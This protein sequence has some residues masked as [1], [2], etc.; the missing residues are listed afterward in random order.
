MDNLNNKQKI[1]LTIITIIIIFI[2]GIFLITK[3]KN[4]ENEYQQYIVDENEEVEE[5]DIEKEKIKIHVIGEVQNTG[6]IEL[7]E[8][9]RISDI[10]EAAGG[11]TENADL[12]KVNLAYEVED[13]QKV[14]IPSINDERVEQ[15]VTNGSGEGII[16]EETKKGLVNINTATQTELET[17][18]GIGPSTALKIITYREENG[19]F[20]S[21]EDIKNIPGIGESKFKNIKEFIYVK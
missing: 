21:I 17:L 7:D 2:I 16:E 20:Q 13:G 14:Y 15:Y 12:S 4:V 8:G 9:A 10:I 3:D 19:K 6:M 1:I 18:P 5:K 11:S